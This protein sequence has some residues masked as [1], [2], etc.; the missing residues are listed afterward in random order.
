MMHRYWLVL[1]LGIFSMSQQEKKT[2]PINLWDS[3][4]LN[5]SLLRIQGEELLLGIQST[6]RAMSRNNNLDVEIN[7]G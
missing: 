1:L 6:L 3:N 4:G 5:H 2:S 7:T